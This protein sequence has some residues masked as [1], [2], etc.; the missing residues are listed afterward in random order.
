[1]VRQCI[2][3]VFASVVLMI[4]GCGGGG[5]SSSPPVTYN[6][7]TFASGYAKAKHEYTLSASSNG[8]TY[9]AQLSQVPGSSSSCGTTKTSTTT[10]TV[11]ISE[12]GT[13]VDNDTY[14]RYYVL[15][16]YKI[17]C[18][19]DATS[20][21]VTIYANQEALPTAASIGDTGSFDT[22]TIYYDTSLTTVF[23][24][25]T[26]TWT[27]NSGSGG[28]ALFCADSV[29]NTNDGDVTES[30]CYSID[31]SGVVHGLTVKLLINGVTLNFQ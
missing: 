25:M 19:Y 6:L 4:A 3:L 14:T 23:G 9:S 21:D 10:V 24:T 17:L 20:G 7:N 30:D 2:A 29:S 27:L 13:L 18:D 12:N 1:M 16:P 26:D 11:N 15:N 8:N 22:A 28:D 31:A 5:S